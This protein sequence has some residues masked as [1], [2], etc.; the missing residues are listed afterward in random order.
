MKIIWTKSN[1][2]VHWYWKD[3]TGIVINKYELSRSKLVWMWN[4]DISFIEPGRKLKQKD[5]YENTCGIA[6]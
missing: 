4:V 1:T 2:N 6:H 5:F 3:R